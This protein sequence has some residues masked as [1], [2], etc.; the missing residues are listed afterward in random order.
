MGGK[1]KPLGIMQEIKSD[2]RDKAYIYKQESV[3]EKKTC[4]IPWEHGI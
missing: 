4:K 2:Y 1:S 3:I